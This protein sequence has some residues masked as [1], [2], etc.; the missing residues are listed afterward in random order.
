MPAEAY[1]IFLSEMFPLLQYGD[2]RVIHCNREAAEKF[3]GCEPEELVGMRL[4]QLQSKEERECGRRQ[5]TLRE[6]HIPCRKQYATVVR[7]LDGVDRGQLRTLRYR[8]ADVS[9]WEVYM[10]SIE[11]VTELDHAQLP[12]LDSH[13]LSQTDVDKACGKFTYRDLYNLCYNKTV[14]RYPKGFCKSFARIVTELEDVATGIYGEPPGS[15]LALALEDTS[16]WSLRDDKAKVRLKASCAACGLIWYRT[17]IR[18]TTWRCPTC[19][20]G[21]GVVPP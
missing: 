4:S 12:P 7:G 15:G 5:H 2:A 9:G 21:G 16:S 18:E 10:V 20:A 8:M 19:Y 17:A 6:N 11:K 1:I 13:G 3:H 14:G